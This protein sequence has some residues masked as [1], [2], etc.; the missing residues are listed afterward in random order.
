[1]SRPEETVWEE[2]PRG[3]KKHAQKGQSRKETDTLEQFK[4]ELVC[5][6]LSEIQGSMESRQARKCGKYQI[7]KTFAGYVRDW[8]KPGSARNPGLHLVME[9]QLTHTVTVS[10]KKLP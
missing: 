4:Q 7:K 5:L 10:S 9:H 1:M 6:E 3:R 2:H 8:T